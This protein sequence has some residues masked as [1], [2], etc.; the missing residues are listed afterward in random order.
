MMEI[1]GSITY[2]QDKQEKQDNLNNEFLTSPIGHEAYAS[3]EQDILLA[4]ASREGSPDPRSRV[5]VSAPR[6]NQDEVKRAIWQ[7]F[8]NGEGHH[9]RYQF[10]MRINLYPEGNEEFIANMTKS[11]QDFKR[12]IPGPNKQKILDLAMDIRRDVKNEN[13]HYPFIGKYHLKSSTRNINIEPDTFVAVW[14]NRQ[15]E[16]YQCYSM[17]YDWETYFELGK[18][19]LTAKQR[20]SNIKGQYLY[21]NSKYDDRPRPLTFAQ[22]RSLGI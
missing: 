13:G 4:Q 3:Q 7:F 10:K 14:W 22:R 8:D 6:F 20:E 2:K 19:R 15:E 17:F 1:G 11:L 16:M 5:P 21:I 12:H 9:R 18:D